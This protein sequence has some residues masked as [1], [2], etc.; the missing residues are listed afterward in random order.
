LGSF[1]H[2]LVTLSLSVPNILLSTLFSNILS[3]GSSLD[4]S[5]QVPHPYV[6]EG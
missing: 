2:F 6:R 1:L 5:D 3:L 4:V